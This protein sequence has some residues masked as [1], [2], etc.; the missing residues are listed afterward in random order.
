MGLTGN[1]R[2]RRGLWGK[3]VLQVEEEVQP[4][5]S[6]S[7]EV[8][9]RWRDATAMDLADPTMRSL[10]DIGR[11]TLLRRYRGSPDRGTVPAQREQR[12]DHE[13]TRRQAP[14]PEGA[15]RTR[16]SAR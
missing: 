10:L 8:K 13:A 1:Y 14:P 5:W 7:G 11:K 6:T 16:P 15:H 9:R 2:L 3:A 12:N 4:L